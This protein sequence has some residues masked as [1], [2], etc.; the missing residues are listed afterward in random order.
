MDGFNVLFIIVTY[1]AMAWVDRCL[2]SID[3]I[4]KG[5]YVKNVNTF[6]VD[7]GSTDGTQDYIS[8]NYPGCVFYQSGSNLGFGKANNIGFQFAVDN[9]FDYVYL[10]NQDAWVYPDTIDKLISV[11]LENPVF[12]VLSPF[13][14]QANEGYL[15]YNFRKNTCSF[16][17]NEELLNDL[18]FSKLKSVYPVPSV[19]AAHWLVSRKCLEEV[20]GF[21]PTFPHY[22]EDGNFSDRV[23][24]HGLKVGIV[25]IAMAVHD[26]EYRK[27]SVEK[28]IYIYYT[29]MLKKYSYIFNK[30]EISFCGI[31]LR[32]VGLVFKR[33]TLCPLK[34]V[35]DLLSRHGEI[36][37]NRS[38]SMK[39]G[40]F[41]NVCD[42][43]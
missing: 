33:K 2:G 19:M 26:R 28:D 8:N 9:G 21:S 15:D 30:Q 12:G 38:F 37:R 25:P 41:L 16:V 3:N 10:L 4:N 6:V 1:N 32:L 24:Y 29:I 7:N 5:L 31:I 13:Q 42:C 18:Y 20:G 40:A 22:S 43:E 34:Y 14:L 17:S 23:Y 27:V 36:K 11:H 35:K 39:A